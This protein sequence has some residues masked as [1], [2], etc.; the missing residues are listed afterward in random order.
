MSNIAI[1]I[2]H[3]AGTG[4]RG[5]GMEEHEQSALT[6]DYLAADLRRRGHTVTVIDFPARGNRGDLN[7]AIAAINGGDY[8]IAI[9]LHM[10]ASDNPAACGAHVCYT[11][12]RGATIAREVAEEL[13]PMLP[14]RAERIV[15]RADLAILNRTGCPAVL[16]ELGFITC[17]RDCK[18]LVAHRAELASKIGCGVDRAL[19]TLDTCEKT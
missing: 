15:R 19:R 9:S 18:I 5:N 16:I 12:T 10:D 17:P 1:D 2:G 8:D 3:A 4:A 13:C 11:S 14:G 6:A 7:A